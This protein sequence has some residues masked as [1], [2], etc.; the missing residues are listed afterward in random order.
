MNITIAIDPGKSGGIA[1]CKDG[2]LG[3]VP[4]PEALP[5]LKEFFVLLLAGTHSP[6]AFV[7]KVPKFVGKAIPS[8]TTAVLFYNYGYTEG[9][10]TAL[11]VRIEQIDPHTWQKYFRL[12]TKKECAST[13]EWKGKLRAEAIR[14]FPTQKVTLATAD[15]LLILDYALAQ[16]KAAAPVERT[17]AAQ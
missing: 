6:V 1:W 4:M 17:T 16:Q 12:G 10:L 13:T 5:E 3:A 15:A 9:V 11:G 2:L 8:S 7:E 14:R